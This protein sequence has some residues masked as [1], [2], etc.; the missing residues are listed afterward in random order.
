MAADDVRDREQAASLAGLHAAEHTAQV[1]NLERQRREADFRAARL[2]LLFCSPTMELG[3][4]IAGLNAVGLRNVPPTPANYAQRSGRAGRSGQPALVTTYCAT[5]NS[6]DAYYFRRSRDM[7]AGAV[8]PPR[9]D[10]GNEDLLRSHV[11]A[12]WL[13][14]TG[15]SLHS[16]LVDLLDVDCEALPLRAE[17]T[18]ALREEGVR[19]RAVERTRA[20]LASVA[21]DLAGTSW[22]YDGWLEDVLGRAAESFDRAGDRW[23]SLYTDARADQEAQNRIV[24]DMSVTVKAREIA[25]GRRREAETQLKLLRNEERESGQSDF[26]SY[27]YFASEGLSLIHI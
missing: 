18:Q 17:I 5:G 4:D 2:P 19:R 20:V 23:R 8:A 25:A 11:H 7:V 26:Y 1:P 21:A 12:I 16:S 9:I 15:Q 13:G 22:W 14:E 6:H 10:L 27:R 3:V 24:L